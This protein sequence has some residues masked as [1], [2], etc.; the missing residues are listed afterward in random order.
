MFLAACN[1]ED[2]PDCFKTAGNITEETRMLEDFNRIE[3]QDLFEVHII[4][5]D[6]SFAVVRGPRNIL[7]KIITDV[8]DGVLFIEN[9]NT[10]N[11]V[12]SFKNKLE[13]DLYVKS[14]RE[15]QNRGTGTI[16]STDTL[17]FPYLKIENRHAAGEVSLIIQ[18]DSISAYTQ[19]GVADIRLAGEVFKAELFNQGYGSIDAKHLKAEQTYINNSSINDIQAYCSGYLFAI[20]YFSGK[21]EVYGAP[22]QT[23]IFRNGNGPIIIH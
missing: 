3:I 23:D 4:P 14:I 18:G 22:D 20:N 10:C 9:N 13:I 2:A 12:R 15:I 19:T 8:T 5:S 17:F 6:S 7:P 1:Q 11:F 21:I 16:F